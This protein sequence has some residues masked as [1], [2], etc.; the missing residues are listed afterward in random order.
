MPLYPDGGIAPVP[1]STLGN[2]NAPFY[3]KTKCLLHG[4]IEVVEVVELFGSRRGDADGFSAYPA[5]CGI[6]PSEMDTDGLVAGPFVVK[7]PT[8]QPRVA[9][10]LALSTGLAEHGNIPIDH[11]S[12]G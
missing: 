12:S 11:P 6:G 7:I 5:L 4:L 10:L 9:F 1:E 2:S 3:A 8:S